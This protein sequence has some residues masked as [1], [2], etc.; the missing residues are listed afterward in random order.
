MKRSIIPALRLL[1]GAAAGLALAA[2]AHGEQ[3]VLKVAHF[4]PATSN[5]Q[6]NMIQPWC[7]RI[8]R[9][10]DQRMVCQIYPAM[11]LGGTPAQ[12]FDQAR[13]GVADIVWTLPTYSAGRFTKSAV[14]ELPWLVPNAEAG[15]R[16]LWA[17]AQ[18]YALDEYK[19]VHPIFMHMHG[20]TLIHFVGK[21]PKTLADMKGLKIRS[22]NRVNSQM[23]EAIGAVPVQMPLPAVPDSLAK[24]VVDGAAV[25]WEGVPA[26]KLDEISR[27]HLDVPKG[28]PRMGNSIFL[29]GMNQARYDSLPPDL[30]KV[31]D[32]NSG[33]EVSAWAGRTVFDEREAEFMKTSRENGSEFHYMDEAEY[34]RWVDATQGVRDLWI[35]AVDKKGG[36]GADL[37]AAARNLVKEFSAGR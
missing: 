3:I 30:K 15:S 19:G 26:I 23:L 33:I 17:F 35:Q 36:Q 25:P 14:Y 31:I 9:E 11:Q 5:A 27:Y 6:L 18:K 20:G 22:A 37:Y 1:A 4:L 10:S 29:F 34:Q 28:K 21:R 12:L 8:A 16:A 13:D 7:D 32:D 2:S 24:G